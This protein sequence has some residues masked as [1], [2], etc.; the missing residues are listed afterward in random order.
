MIK[1]VR[2][3]KEEERSKES[4]RFILG[5]SDFHPC[6]LEVSREVSRNNRYYKEEMLEGGWKMDDGLK[7]QPTRESRPKC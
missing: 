1:N 5:K 3:K 4:P 7:I 6:F 2:W